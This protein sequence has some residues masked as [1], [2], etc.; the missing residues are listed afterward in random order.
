M[1]G[2]ECSRWMLWMV[3]V[4]SQ[5]ATARRDESGENWIAEMVSVGGGSVDDMMRVGKEGHS[6]FPSDSH[7]P[8]IKETY[9]PLVE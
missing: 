7:L 3:S 1:V 4:L 8:T 9:P 6:H 5:L 2:S